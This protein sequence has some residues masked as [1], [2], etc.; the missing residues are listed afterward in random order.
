VIP[1]CSVGHIRDP[2]GTR[3]FCPSQCADRLPV[4]IVTGGGGA[5]FLEIEQSGRESDRLS[6][7]K[8]ETK[9]VWNCTAIACCL[10][11]RVHLN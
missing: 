9:N 4:Q 10:L 2:A 8:L 7:S 6:P 11:K 5:P 3:F 1:V